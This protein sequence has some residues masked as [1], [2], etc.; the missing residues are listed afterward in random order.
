MF[1]PSSDSRSSSTLKPGPSSRP[2]NGASTFLPALSGNSLALSACSSVV[3]CPHIRS[4]GSTVTPR[5]SAPHPSP[6][7]QSTP[8]SDRPTT[9]LP[10]FDEKGRPFRYRC[11]SD[12][13][14]GQQCYPAHG[15]REGPGPL[16]YSL[17]ASYEGIEAVSCTFPKQI[18]YPSLAS[19]QE[20]I[21]RPPASPGSSDADLRLT[22]DIPTASTLVSGPSASGSRGVPLSPSRSS[23]QLRGAVTPVLS[24]SSIARILDASVAVS[25]PKRV[26]SA[27]APSPCIPPRLFSPAF[28]TAASTRSLYGVPTSD[29]S[30]AAISRGARATGPCS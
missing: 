13:V 23:L 18:H 5:I 28:P 22:A 7:L 1:P 25:R 24:P 12:T 26:T 2:I 27:A 16:H 8:S 4:P 10:S 21:S 9:F 19:V 6:Y 29:G 15:H 3:T 30:A 11:Q 20:D 14:V 17:P